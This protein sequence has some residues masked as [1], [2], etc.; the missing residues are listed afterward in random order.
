MATDSISGLQGELEAALAA[1]EPQITG[2]T[3]LSLHP[4]SSG[5]AA[6]LANALAA[7]QHRQGLIQQVLDDIEKLLEDLQTL[8]SDGYP[9][10]Q[11]FEISD[12]L[13]GELNNEVI[14][15]QAGAGVFHGSGGSMAT[16]LQISL[17]E[18]QPKPPPVPSR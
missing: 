1:L 2:V 3:D 17:G 14:E 11:T 6:E 5:L 16:T 7:L 4:V 9:I 8:E 12:P 18:P 15:V 10:P 13:L